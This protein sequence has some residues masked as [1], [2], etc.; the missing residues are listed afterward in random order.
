MNI[1]LKRQ[2]F[3]VVCAIIAI[4]TCVPG[5]RAQE[6]RGSIQGTIL[7][8]SEAVVPR[9][10]VAATN[11]GTNVTLKATTNQE[12]LYNLMF[13]LPGVYSISVSA[14]G[15]KTSRRDNIQLPIHERL[16]IDFSLELGAVNEQ[17][18]ITAEAPLLQTAT[19]NL[20]VVIDSRRIA[21]LPV[22]QGSPFSLMYLSPGV[23]YALA[24]ASPQQ[25]PQAITADSD[26]L[27]INGAPT[28]TSD[29][30]I[31]GIP[32]TQT[33]NTGNGFTYDGSAASASPPA[34]IVDEFKVENA[35]DASVGHNSGTVMNISLKT[36]T[37]TPHGTAYVFDREPGWN[38]NTFFANRAGQ[39]LGQF[40]YKRWGTSLSGPVFIP[41]VYNG[42]NRTFFIY[43][44]EGVHVNNVGL[45]TGTVPS[46]A[47]SAGDFSNLLA[48]GGQYQI[49]D[50]TTIQAAANGR[51]SRQ[52]FAGNIIPASRISPIAKN[53]L[54]LYPKTT[55]PGLADGENDYIQ[56]RPSPEVYFNHTARVDH[57]ISDKQRMYTRAQMVHRVT[58][59]YRDN[60]DGPA[61]GERYY[62]HAPQL[63]FD[64]VYTLSPNTVLNFRYGY[65]RYGAGHF[66]RLLDYDVS[67]LGFSSTVVPLLTGVRKMLPNLSIAGMA[68]FANESVDYD[69]S[70]VHSVFASVSKQHKS[71]SLHFGLDQRV[72]RETLGQ[73]GY[74]GGSF[75]FSTGY[76]NGPLDSS[77]ASPLGLG[78]GLAAFLLG[79]P[80][81]GLIA[82][83]ATAASQSTF[84]A[85][86]LHDSWRASRK[87]TLDLGLRWEYEG[88][89]TERY[90]R[91]VRG[92][93]PQ[94]VQAIQAP[95]QAAYAA[96]P[97]PA[98]S[99]NNFQVRGGLLFAGLGGVPRQLWDSS[100]RGFAPR[101]GLSYQALSRLVI[102]GGFG[103]FP[104]ERGIPVLGRAMQ[105]GFSQ[106][107]N[108]V[109]TL[110]GGQT[111]LA[112]LANPFPNGVLQPPGASLGT[113]T[114]LGNAIS[115]HDPR[116]KLPY[117]MHWNFNTQEMLPGRFLLEVG[118]HGS[119]TVRLYLSRNI[120]SLP[121]SYLSTL[122]VR[123]QTTINYLSASIS[124]PL[125]G[126]LPGTS[127]NGATIGRSS[128]LV[129]FPEFGSITIKDPQGYSWFHALQ[130]RLER[131][132]S[133]GFTTQVGYSFSKLMEAVAY[134][135]AADPF[136]YRTIASVDRP[137]KLTFSAIQEMPFG[138]GKPLWGGAS[139]LTDR[140]IGGWQV[141][142]IWTLVS[143]AMADFGNVLPLNTN[144]VLPAD[145]RSINQ[146]FNI[147]AFDR[148]A[149]DQLASNLRTFPL[150]F[151]SL[152]APFTN[153][154]DFSVLKKTKIYERYDFQFRAETFNGLNH[155]IFGLPGVSPTASTFGV[156]TATSLAARTMQ[157]G[158]KLIF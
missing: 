66:P 60:Y 107:T 19:A 76:T 129:P 25:S 38:A 116:A 125:A 136:P 140:V 10:V 148:I 143:G 15:F 16:Q 134:L 68:P 65:I 131:R 128:L 71:H 56:Q 46:A 133:H 92:F 79:Q 55:G 85:V 14:P 17:V 120:N 137:Q 158:F 157:M 151:S 6:T 105:T 23:V 121:D 18:Q 64:D 115:F 48:L 32:N 43:G 77:P 59:P 86:Y 44:Y 26:F 135:N 5:A 100:L 84:W 63:A 9:V 118:Y 146:W 39:P 152:R 37:N 12:G 7:D 28:A 58:G 111:F 124:N 70:D 130:V 119:R 20:G 139:R 122:P 99:A 24:G 117:D 61:S 82:R 87:L 11:T 150:R 108:L 41:K 95:A 31:D 36:G 156:V 29:F 106:N 104:I 155:A 35:F 103:V 91:S 123:D 21:E 149:A 112:N 88:P 69:N 52:P 78:Q 113:A 144:I 101:F 54:A 72:Y 127:L 67:G 45:Y 141:G 73:V 98:L 34:D 62:G 97:D 50:P 142:A 154:W 83:N 51:Y 8:G 30:T 57:M 42:R 53:L 33:S 47:N 4:W 94:V 40:T 80:D 138:R 96:A 145:Q 132:F 49:Y 89:T 93:D 114:N 2:K 109:A 147:N 110:N 74:A 22:A 13:L 3:L 75:T 27:S 102:R 126:L 81:S 90:N 153:S 1:I